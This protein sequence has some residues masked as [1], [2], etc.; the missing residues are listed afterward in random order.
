MHHAEANADHFMKSACF[1]RAGLD[2]NNYDRSACESYFAAY[3]ECKKREVGSNIC[4][5]CGIA[6]PLFI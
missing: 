4:H 2:R 1:F 5:N 6:P 3:K